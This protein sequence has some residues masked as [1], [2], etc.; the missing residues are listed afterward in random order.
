MVNNA[1]RLVLVGAA[2]VLLTGCS[3]NGDGSG[4]GVGALGVTTPAE[5][6]AKVAGS[7]VSEEPVPEVAEPL[8]VDGIID[9]PC[10]ALGTDQLGALGFA[11]PGEL[12]TFGD[13]LGCDWELTTSGLHIVTIRPLVSDKGG[14]NDVYDGRD[15]QAYFEPTTVDGYPAV[16]ASALDERDSGGCTLLVGLTDELVVSVDTSFL[17]VEPCPVAEQTAEAMIEHLRNST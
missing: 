15:S 10:D 13:D 17:K 8:E 9:E 3:G 5:I 7:A 14:L 6:S 1:I 4:F 11:G 2:M 16:Y 12:N